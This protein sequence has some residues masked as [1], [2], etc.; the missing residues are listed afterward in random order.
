[1]RDHHHPI[2]YTHVT[3]Q[4]HVT[5]WQWNHQV[6]QSINHI[7]LLLLILSDWNRYCSSAFIYILVQGSG[8]CQAAGV[9]WRICAAWVLTTYIHTLLGLL[10]ANSV[11]ACGCLPSRATKTPPCLPSPCGILGLER[12]QSTSVSPSHSHLP[13]SSIIS[14]LLLPL[15]LGPPSN[16][17]FSWN[18]LPEVCSSHKAVPPPPPLKHFS[19]ILQIPTNWHHYVDT[20]LFHSFF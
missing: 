17:D 3:K 11:A 19:L 20:P 7:C 13:L 12:R 18:N 10:Q 15:L 14:T 4:D 5:R 6:G 2:L 8:Q 1:M 16:L 9:G